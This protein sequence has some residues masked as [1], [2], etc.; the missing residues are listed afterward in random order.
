MTSSHTAPESES[1]ADEGDI[2]HDADTSASF[3]EADD[4][5]ES[6]DLSRSPRDMRKR[7]LAKIGKLAQERDRLAHEI[8]ARNAETE[9]MV[10]TRI[11][12]YE[13]ERADEFERKSFFSSRPDAN[14]IETELVS[15]R[16]TFPTMS[17]EEA[18]TFHTAQHAPEKLV[19][20]RLIAQKKSRALDTSA[21]APS[22]LRSEP[23]ASRMSAAEYGRYLDVLIAGGKIEL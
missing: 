3:S 2:R 20:R 1:L 5:S 16:E 9:R 23:D 13:S 15:L 4:S 10:D 7:Y 17:W 14:E 12:A 19:D 18:Y 8:T 21:Y 22:R 6:I 11:R